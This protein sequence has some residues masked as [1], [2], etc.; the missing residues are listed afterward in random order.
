[1]AAG[2]GWTGGVASHTTESKIDIIQ[3]TPGDEE[4]FA[5]ALAAIRA[6]DAIRNPGDPQIGPEEMSA[7]YFHTPPDRQQLAFVATL[8]GEPAGVVNANTESDP[9]DELQVANIEAM[10]LPEAR[11]YGVATALVEAVVPPLKE[12]GQQSIMAWPCI[13]ISRDASTTMCQKYDMTQR[14]EERC[15]RVAVADIDEGLMASWVDSAASAAPGY[16]LASWIGHVPDDMTSLWSTAMKGMADAPM[17][18]LDFNYPTRD[19][20][21]QREADEMFIGAGFSLLR[22]VAI[23][24]DGDAAGLSEIFVH[25]ERPQIGHQSDTTV[26]E[27]HRGHR[28]GKWLKAAN[29]QHTRGNVPELS[30]LETYNAQS[31]AH[32]LDIN[33]A[34]GFRPHR[35]YQAWQAPIDDVLNRIG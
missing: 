24:P 25:R 9:D 6:D 19:A 30:V 33:V 22:T 11:R 35:T 17:D 13:E 14:Q 2:S 8:N 28:L 32:M 15:S 31:N 26:L 5:I 16:R 12:M 23:G 4:A 10:V 7:W 29:Y 3:V 27:S 34:M 21:A 1:M 18:D 20:E